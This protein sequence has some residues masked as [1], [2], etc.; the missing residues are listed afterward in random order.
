MHPPAGDDR[1]RPRGLIAPRR[2]LEPRQLDVLVRIG[3]N[4]QHLPAS[5]R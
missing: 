4:Q 3:L 2:L 5:E 1:V